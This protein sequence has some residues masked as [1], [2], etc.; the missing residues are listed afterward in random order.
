MWERL[1][2]RVLNAAGLGAFLLVW[3]VGSQVANKPVFFPRP[4]Q[5]LTAARELMGTG[6]LLEHI[7]TSLQR[8]MVGFGLALVVAV[9]VGVLM[10]LSPR[11][12]AFF[13]PIVEVLRPVPALA[14]V[15]VLLMVVGIKPSIYYAVT[16]YGSLFPMLINT[17]SGV[18]TMDRQY[19]H[20]AAS[21]GAGPLMVMREVAFPAAAP[22]I[23][24]GARIG[25]GT[26]W[27]SIIAA[28]LVGASSGL[29]YMINWYQK[30]FD[31]G[32]V[33]VGMLAIGVIGYGLNRLMLVLQRM[34]T[35]WNA[36]VKQ[37][38]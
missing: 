31:S 20:A 13:D 11:V 9:L 29:G 30:S 21:L 19:L 36:G 1:G 33:V 26:G 34:L 35:P 37:E 7:L 14:W 28:E 32:R 25:M 3:Q 2:P 8:V 38:D 24:A 10:G 12:F 27:Y 5:A 16:F 23:I 15:P 18:R 22:A 4:A 17:V 6:E